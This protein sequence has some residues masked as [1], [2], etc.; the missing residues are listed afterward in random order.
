M[1]VDTTLTH[2]HRNPNYVTYFRNRDDIMSTSPAI[3]TTED[4]IELLTILLSADIEDGLPSK[5]FDQFSRERIHRLYM[6]L[7][8]DKS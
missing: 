1:V 6:K 3:L 2:L 4:F 5:P 8:G 7:L